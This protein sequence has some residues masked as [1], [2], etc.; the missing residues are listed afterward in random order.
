MTTQLTERNDEY[1]ETELG[2]LPPNWQLKKLGELCEIKSGGTPSTSKKEFWKNGDVPWIKSGQ[3]QNCF[4]NSAQQFI[5][6]EGLENS[7]AKMFKQNTVLVA[8]VGATVG[9][10]GFLS[11]DAC[12]NQ[13]VAGLYPKEDSLLDSLYLFFCLQDRYC[14]FTKTKGFIIANL[15]FI[16]K[17]QIPRPPLLEQKNIAYI[18]FTIQKARD[19][20]DIVLNS[21]KELKKSLM[22]HLFTFGAVSLEDADKVKLRETDIGNIPEEWNVRKLGDVGE[23]QYG[24]TETASEKEIG[25][26]FVRITDIDLGNNRVKWN[27]V[28][29]CKI[30]E[31]GYEKFKLNEGDIL[32]A[33][34]GATTGKTCIVRKPPESVYA[35]Y[36]IRFAANGINPLF[37]YQFT[38]TELYW[39]QIAANK[40]GK[41]KKG[42]NSS[43]LKKFMIPFPSPQ[44]QEQIASILSSV[45]SKIETEERKRESLDELFKSMLHN[46]MTAKIRVNNFGG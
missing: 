32:I 10:T 11:F 28:P 29:F 18:L 12:S 19:K 6:R 26:R 38:L 46:L 39:K 35:S 3:C 9:K 1:K 4:V 44:E 42:V 27:H 13:N 41:V 7:S 24:Y 21:L 37:V 33:R 8:M 5:T 45:D 30:S 14:E 34:I 17:L 31:N 36:L 40:E 25:P 15:S 22:K 2:S 16:K 43:Q 20:T 23:F